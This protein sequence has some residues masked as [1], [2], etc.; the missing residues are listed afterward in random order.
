MRTFCFNFSKFWS[1]NKCW[2]FN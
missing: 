2:L 1:F